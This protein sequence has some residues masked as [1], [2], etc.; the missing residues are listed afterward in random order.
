[1]RLSNVAR[2]VGL[3]VLAATL[4][5]C[6]KKDVDATP[7]PTSPGAAQVKASDQ[8]GAE[9]P[10]AAGP[11]AAPAAGAPAAKKNDDKGGW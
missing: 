9:A 7:E 10:A 6:P 11:A 8:A 3:G 2:V 1:M 4:L 5:G